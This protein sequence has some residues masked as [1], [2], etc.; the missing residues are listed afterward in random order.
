MSM[1]EYGWFLCKCYIPFYTRDLHI[2]R[3]GYL[4]MMGPHSAQMFSGCSPCDPADDPAYYCVHR[5]ISQTEV[6]RSLCA[7]F[8]AFCHSFQIVPSCIVC[9]TSFWHS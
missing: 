1:R 8:L 5:S 9:S 3:F 2:L 4:G 6:Q 7:L